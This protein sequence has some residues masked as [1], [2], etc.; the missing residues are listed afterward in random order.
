MK[1]VCIAASFVPSN[2]ANSIQVM[3]ATH[4]LAALGHSVTL[5]VPGEGRTDWDF[6]RG[7][8]GLQNRLEVEWIPE[9]LIRFSGL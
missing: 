2:T 5:L 6:L 3:K 9:N 7:F 4:A 1:I 8:Y